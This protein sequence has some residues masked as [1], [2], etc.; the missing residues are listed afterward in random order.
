MSAGI[1]PTAAGA[2]RILIVGGST[3]AA[4]WSAFRAGFQPVCAD[5]F[6]DQD[7]VEVADVVPVRNYPNSLPE[8]ISGVHA[9]GWIY[10]GGLENRS[11]LIKR[12]HRADAPY[13]PLWGTS[14]DALRLV[15]NPFWVRETLAQTGCPAL[16]VRSALAPP[17]ADGQWV[18]KPLSSGGGRAVCIWDSTAQQAAKEAVYYQQRIAGLTMSALY[19]RQNDEIQFLGMSRQLTEV[20]LSR[21]PEAFSYGGSIGPLPKTPANDD[22]AK[23]LMTAVSVVASR[24]G[25]QGLF[26]VDFIHDADGVPWILEINPRY[27]ASVEIL[28][29]AFQQS[30]MGWSDLAARANGPTVAKMILY[31]DRTLTAP[32]LSCLQGETGPW[33]VPELADIPV[34]GTHVESGWP[35][36]T[37]LATG[38]DE[39]ECLMTLHRRAADV[40]ASVDTC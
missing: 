4:A 32:D 10:T 15:R 27:T 38:T 5:L 34:A 11:D 12:M 33:Q 25:I 1:A 39:N 2:G 17:P 35:I 9:D 22:L 20:A 16:E 29:L 24:S 8:D 30:F 26:G 23:R 19:R 21:L 37:V 28:E 13:G 7:T 31:A 6:A 36:C 3:R 18:R 40:W 14:A